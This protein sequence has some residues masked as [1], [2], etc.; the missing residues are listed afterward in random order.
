VLVLD[1]DCYTTSSFSGTGNCVE[2]MVTPAGTWVRDTKDR[3][4]PV[5]RFTRA[6]FA[7]WAEGVATRNAYTFELREIGATDPELGAPTQMGVF[8]RCP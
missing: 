3:G 5:L 1:A 2:V 6:E 8:R 7:A 4:G